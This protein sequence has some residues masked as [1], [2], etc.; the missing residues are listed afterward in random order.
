MRAHKHRDVWKYAG[1]V[2]L[3]ILSVFSLY[4]TIGFFKFFHTSLDNYVM[5]VMEELHVPGVALAI[6]KDDAITYIK[7][8]G[9][10]EVGKPDKITG[11]TPFQIGSCSK[12]FTAAAL[13]L[14]VDEGKIT[15]NDKTHTLL[16]DFKLYDSYVT[17]ELIIADMLSHR[18]GIEDIG[19]LC[20]LSPLSR[21]QLIHQM[22]YL[23]PVV[24]FRISAVYNN[25]MYLAAGQ[26]VPQVA[27]MSW[28]DF[29]SQR[30]FEPLA[31]KD[32]TANIRVLKN[33]AILAKPHMLVHDKIIS[34]I[35]LDLYN[36]GPAG[37][38]ISTAR[39]MAQWVRMLLNNG[40]YEGS[41]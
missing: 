5:Q 10:L 41:I 21:D 27:G 13:A 25:F 22:R 24:D 17:K 16:P 23:S 40:Q 3:L 38:I 8:Y 32:S 35:P 37:S 9:V 26:I 36:V 39:D 14:L 30:F 1:I 7:G 12:A 15:W 2:G 29:I 18:S 33:Q 34:M 11:D 19:L 4:Y 31:M 20:F 28:D 6:I